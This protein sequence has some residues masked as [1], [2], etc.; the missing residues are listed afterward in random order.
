MEY[1]GVL[2]DSQFDA[3]KMIEY[4]GRTEGFAVAGIQ[5]TADVLDGVAAGNLKVTKNL[6]ANPPAQRASRH[7][8]RRLPLR[9]FSIS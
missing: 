1:V 6:L 5:F 2:A 7:S 3:E 8:R 4:I 9:S